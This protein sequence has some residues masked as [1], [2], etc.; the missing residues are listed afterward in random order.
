[1]I[2]DAKGRTIMFGL[3]EERARAYARSYRGSRAVRCS[4]GGAR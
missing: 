1:M 2:L 4:K 3:T